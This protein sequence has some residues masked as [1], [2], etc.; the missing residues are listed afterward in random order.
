[1]Y[2]SV[3]Q[4][5][6][7]SQKITISN[8]QPRHAK[9][10]CFKLT[11]GIFKINKGYISLNAIVKLRKWLRLESFWVLLHTPYLALENLI[12]RPRLS[13]QRPTPPQCFHFSN[14][15]PYIDS[16]RIPFVLVI[17]LILNA[18][19]DTE[20]S[21][22]EHLAKGKLYLTEENYEK[23]QIAFKNVLQINPKSAEAYHYLGEIAE[24]KRD[25]GRVLAS[26]NSALDLNPE[27]LKTRQNLGR[28]FY[29]VA[30]EQEASG[31]TEGAK[32]T[33]KEV[34][35]QVDEILKRD[36][37]HVGGLVLK[38]ALNFRNN[39]TIEAIEML[40][41][42]LSLGMN[43][44]AVIMLSEIYAQ[45][46]KYEK[47]EHILK[48][49][50]MLSPKNISIYLALVEYYK[51]Q[52][53]MDNA[54]KSLNKVIQIKPDVF[55]YRVI[56]SKY[57]TQIDQKDNAVKVLRNSVRDESMDI[58]R[59]L[60][61]AE[62]VG[63][64][65]GVEA[66]I[67][68][69]KASIQKLPEEPKLIFALAGVYVREDRTD[70]ALSLFEGIIDKWKVS[71]I[72]LKA[73]I[74][75]AKIYISRSQMRKAYHL[76]DE[77]LDETPNDHDALLLKG[78]IALQDKKNAEA[79]TAF[80]IIL[81]TQPDKIEVLNLIAEAHLAEGSMKLAHENLMKVVDLL[82]N[83]V[84]ALSR[85]VRYFIVARDK[86]NI[87]KYI[88]KVLEIEPNNIEALT[89]KSSILTASNKIEQAIQVLNK[90]K[91]IAPEKSDPYFRM[92]RIYKAQKKLIKAKKEFE[93]AFSRDP[94][95]KNLLAELIDLQLKMGEISEAEIMLKN[96]IKSEPEFE[97]AYQFI[98]M[99]FLA[100]KDFSSA[101]YAFNKAYMRSADVN[102]LAQLIS[103]YV[104]DKDE[105]GAR[106][107]LEGIIKQYPDHPTAH[108]LLGVLYQQQNM[109][110]E[111][112]S[113][114]EQQ[115]KL[116]PKSTDAY[117]Q[118][119]N[120]R[121][122]QNNIEGAKH[123]YKQGIRFLPEDIRL[124]HRLAMLYESQQKLDKAIN[125]Y[126]KIL[127]IAPSN[128][129]ATNN[130]ASLLI[131]HQSNDE[132][133]KRAF[134]LASRLAK[135]E[136]PMFV[137][138][139][140]WVNYKLGKYIEAVE[141]LAPV[142]DSMPDVAMFRYHLGMSYFKLG[143]SELAHKHLKK[144]IE[145]GKFPNMKEAKEVLSVLQR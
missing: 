8:K 85:L 61:L 99:V 51:R 63:T 84:D 10:R 14:I 38:A 3:I 53:Q 29:L 33:L 48:K 7:V 92:G 55:N 12:S 93:E 34:R 27:L 117:I 39:K 129:L 89:I 5:F 116:T 136:N 142:V 62:Y 64:H 69:L 95:S 76:I 81:K 50:L 74:E 108:S 101:K 21:V 2:K 138:T 4:N 73:R 30:G 13:Q 37:N 122:A 109:L 114:F 102:L 139:F 131:E 83:N 46:K 96:I 16:I 132:N 28:Y 90:L 94:K 23:A 107:K 17:I 104:A 98:G 115:V 100:K 82:P 24:Y 119:A 35:K 67:K 56:L 66:G 141:I 47:E 80:R 58:D 60:V 118:L 77:V 110:R 26:Y 49:G 40:E 25:W 44:N 91:K 1:M 87:K 123:A 6:I 127:K 9:K 112:E 71:P 133:L 106:A 135:S 22:N 45:Q 86:E 11:D 54:I 42:V 75:S 78:K 20:K 130:L 97:M 52:K 68:E 120:I 143:K 19:G 31:N 113:E 41:R 105:P 140:G 103:A 43:E 126:E 59:H 57:Y 124:L 145:I 121:V 36:P 65:K 128:V 70:D 137:D 144:A 18:C 79:I 15:S 125:N 111:A 134:N 72:G 88:N 32:E